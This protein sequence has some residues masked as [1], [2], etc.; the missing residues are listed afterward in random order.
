M[1]PLAQLNPQNMTEQS[2]RGGEGPN[3]GAPSSGRSGRSGKSTGA[4]GGIAELL[5][6]TR[7]PLNGRMSQRKSQGTVKLPG[8]NAVSAPHHQ[9]GY[10]RQQIMDITEDSNTN[11]KNKLTLGSGGVHEDTLNSV[12]SDR[13]NGNHDQNN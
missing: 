8:Q 6:S 13:A 5:Q 11:S 2:P 12:E 9:L 10:R 7:G 4:T 1:L 3:G